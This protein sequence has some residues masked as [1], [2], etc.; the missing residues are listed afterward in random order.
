VPGN[1]HPYRDPQRGR[2]PS[3]DTKP[4]AKKPPWKKVAGKSSK[5]S[6]TSEGTTKSAVG[7][8]EKK[9]SEKIGRGA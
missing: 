5:E 2:D 1:W 6:R 8:A 4:A 7:S 9:I 3:A